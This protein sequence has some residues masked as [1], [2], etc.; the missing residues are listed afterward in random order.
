MVK[1]FPIIAILDQ[2]IREPLELYAT[3]ITL[4]GVAHLISTTDESNYIEIEALNTNLT[5]E[6]VQSFHSDQMVNP[7]KLLSIPIKF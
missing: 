7:K 4:Q 1:L 5:F 6:N 3:L 2:A